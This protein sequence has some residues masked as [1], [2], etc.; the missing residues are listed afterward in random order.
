MWNSIEMIDAAAAVIFS[1]G[2]VMFVAY[3]MGY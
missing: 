1:I 3:M 2:A